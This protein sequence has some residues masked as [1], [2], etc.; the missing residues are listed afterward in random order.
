[1]SRR[2]SPPRPHVGAPVLFDVPLFDVPLFDVPLFD[3]PRNSSTA[4]KC[5]VGVGAP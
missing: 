5:G 4:P 2:C 1:V 3:V